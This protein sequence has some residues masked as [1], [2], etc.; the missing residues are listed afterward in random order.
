MQS[1]RK[2]QDDPKFNLVTVKGKSRDY[3]CLVEYCLHSPQ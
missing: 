3:D 1:H 2:L